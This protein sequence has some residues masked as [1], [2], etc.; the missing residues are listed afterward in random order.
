MTTNIQSLRAEDVPR[1][2][3]ICFN[4]ECPMREECLRHAV[5]PIVAASCD[6][7]PCVYPSA[8]VGG[9]C[10]FFVDKQPIRLAWGFRPLFTKVRHEDYASLRWKV[11]A[12]FGSDSQ[13]FRYNRGYYKLTPEQQ[14][15]V[16]DIF[17]RNGYDTTDF[18]FAHYADSY[19]FNT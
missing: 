18:R 2:W 12:L 1:S 3:Q 7:G 6:H 9:K 13:F 11:I 15:E 4:D 10:N 17:R 8:L 14:E 5:A 19:K 16:L